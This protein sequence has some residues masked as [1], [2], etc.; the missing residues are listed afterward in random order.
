[1]IQADTQ[2][3][4]RP[5][6]ES[7]KDHVKSIH[8]LVEEQNARPLEEGQQCFLVSRS[9]L[10][11][12]PDLK[13]PKYNIEDWSSI[14]LVDNSDIVSEVINDPCVGETVDI[15]KRKF[16]RLK[17]G[18][19]LEQFEPF[20]QA[21]GNSWRNGP[22]SRT[23]KY[24]SF[25]RLTRREKMARTSCGNGI[26]PSSLYIEFGLRLMSCLGIRMLYLRALFAVALRN[27]RS[28]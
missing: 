12:V 27:S 23:I 10:A 25:A 6:P 4:A 11:K 2:V 3:E 7:M 18:Y 9:W 28:S 22:D 26:L 19:D 16:V 15:L 17:P 1:M 24:R 5:L 8:T 13:S 21:L 20:P 14:P